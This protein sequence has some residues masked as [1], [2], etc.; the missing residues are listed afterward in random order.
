MKWGG[1][2]LPKNAGKKVITQGTAAN[3]FGVTF[4]ASV[5]M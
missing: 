5:L 4:V 2:F 1:D 3:L